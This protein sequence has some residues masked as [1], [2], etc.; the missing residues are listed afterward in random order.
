MA[1][2]VLPA[3]SLMAGL[4]NLLEDGTKCKTVLGCAKASAGKRFNELV[5]TM[6][7]TK[8]LSFP[9]GMRDS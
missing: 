4:R 9:E 1:S 2:E 5:S 7:S 6:K 8:I 3:F